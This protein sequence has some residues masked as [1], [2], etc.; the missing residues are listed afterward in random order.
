MSNV[1]YGQYDSNEY[2]LKRFYEYELPLNIKDVMLKLNQ[3]KLAAFRGGLAFVYLLD[4]RGYLLKDLDMVAYP[5]CLEKILEYLEDSDIV[6]VNKNTF[7][8]SVITA[9]WRNL[10][11]YYKL[12]ILLCEEMPSLCEK[13]IDEK[14]LR[15]VAP[16]YLWR[17]RIEKIA[18]KETRKHDGKKTLN[19]FYVAS[20]LSQYLYKNRNELEEKDINIVRIKLH[21]AQ[22]V[23][24]KLLTKM[25]VE[26]FMKLQLELVG[27]DFR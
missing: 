12:D 10:D 25:E 19:H 2:T 6:Y 15:I 11:D 13:N 17:N 23:L 27:V 24:S 5:H 22:N 7:G 1:I 9:F 26:E 14:V 20:E 8:D 18:E 4:E 21:D 3:D 16:S